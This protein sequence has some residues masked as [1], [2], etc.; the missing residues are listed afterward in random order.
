MIVFLLKIGAENLFKLAGTI[1]KP[2]LFF[3]DII[4]EYLMIKAVAAADNPYLPL[5]ELA[6]RYLGV[7]HRLPLM[8]PTPHPPTLVWMLWPLGWLSYDWAEWVWFAAELI[9]LT[10]SISLIVRLFHFYL[11]WWGLPLATVAF[12]VWDVVY[13]ELYYGQLM[14]MILFFLTGTLLAALRGRRTLAGLLFGISLLIKPMAWP[15]FMYFALRRD[16]RILIVGAVSTLTGYIIA[17]FCVGFKAIISYF[18]LI[19]P[20][21]NMIYR[22]EYPNLSL[23]SVGYR[24]FEGSTVSMMGKQGGAPPCFQASMLG[25]ITAVA[26]TL[27]VLWLLLQAARR[28]VDDMAI[29]S[30]FVCASFLISPIAWNH[31]MV[32]LILP[33]AFVLHF[34]IRHNFPV[35]YTRIAFIIGVVLAL[36]NWVRLLPPLLL[37]GELVRGSPTDIIYFNPLVGLLAFFPT[38]AVCSLACLIYRLASDTQLAAQ[39]VRSGAQR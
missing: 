31:Y 37:G 26:L 22:S 35:T 7:P 10:A 34:L 14:I 12:V 16:W 1:G 15:L 20:E 38:V 19:V 25:D 2:H 30:L 17:A 5:P 18:E 6:N 13:T 8:H 24:L 23:L 4:Q 3:K 32:V 27:T 21:V 11:P 29:F 36:P 9:V 33:F 28:T 39:S